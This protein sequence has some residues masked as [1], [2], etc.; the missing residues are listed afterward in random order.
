MNF[1][2]ISHS[3]TLSRYKQVKSLIW[4]Y[5]SLASR[6]NLKSGEHQNADRQLEPKLHQETILRHPILKVLRCARDARVSQQQYDV[7]GKQHPQENA[8]LAARHKIPPKDSDAHGESTGEQKVSGGPV[9]SDSPPGQPREEPPE[10]CSP[11]NERHEEEHRQ[12]KNRALLNHAPNASDRA[13]RRNYPKSERVESNACRSPRKQD[14]EMNPRLM[15]PRREV[16]RYQQECPEGGVTACNEYPISKRQHVSGRM[17]FSKCRAVL[18]KGQW[19][20]GSPYVRVTRHFGR[21]LQRTY[22]IGKPLGQ[23]HHS[24]APATHHATPSSTALLSF[25]L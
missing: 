9:R 7:T 15:P 4:L 18:C 17:I 12:H 11:S 5:V 10:P 1:H 21:V 16:E 8:K 6:P 19:V 2:V 22:S 14:A 23:P 3:G 24:I 20:K 13:W 25:D